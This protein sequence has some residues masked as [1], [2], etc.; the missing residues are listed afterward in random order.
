MLPEMR[1]VQPIF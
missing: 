1:Y